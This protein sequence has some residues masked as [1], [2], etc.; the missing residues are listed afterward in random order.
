MP[1]LVRKTVSSILLLC[2]LV[3]IGGY[4]LIYSLYQ[5]NLKTEMKAF[6]KQNKSSQFGTRFEFTINNNQVTDPK[7]SWEE[8]GEEFRYQHELYD[9]VSLEKKQ[10]KLIVVCLKDKDENQLEKQLDEIHKSNKS[11]NSKTAQNSIKFFSVFYLEK[12]NNHFLPSVDTKAIIAFKGASIR[13]IYCNIQLPPP[14][15]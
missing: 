14:R 5:Q 9:I 4:H 12:I 15:C 8:E 1:V 7:F 10:G 6:L 3:Y 11:T 13:T 2:L